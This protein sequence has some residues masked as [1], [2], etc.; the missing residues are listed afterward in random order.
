[1]KKKENVMK[2]AAVVMCGVLL[3]ATCLGAGEIPISQWQVLGPFLNGLRA[4]D[5]DFLTAHGGEESIVPSGDQIFYAEQPEGGVLRWFEVQT[6]GPDVKVKY[7]N[8]NWPF[9]HQRYGS[10][11]RSEGYMNVGY[12]YAEL[13]VKERLRILVFTKSVPTLWINGVRMDGEFYTFGYNG[14]P[15]VLLPGKNRLLLKF[16]G[17]GD[18]HFSCSI[19]KAASSVEILDDLT[20]PDILRDELLSSF[21]GVPIANT[22]EQWLKNLKLVVEEDGRFRKTETTIP[23]MAPLSVMKVPLTLT[24]ASMLSEESRSHDITVA[25]RDGS[26]TAA[27]VKVSLRVKDRRH[28]HKVTFLSRIDGSVQYYGIRYPRHYDPD[29]TYGVLFSLHGSGDEAI[30]MAEA[31]D[32]KDWA[33]VVATTDR[34]PW[35]LEYHAWGHIDLH[36]VLDLVAAR[37]NID[38]DRISLTGASMGGH[39]SLFHSLMF[40]SK[41]AAAAPEAS[42]PSPMILSSSSLSRS[43]IYAVPGLRSF[44]A[45]M[46]LDRHLLSLAENARHMPLFMIH[47]GNDDVVYP[48][49]PRLFQSRVRDLGIPFRYMEVP[50]RPHFWFEPRTEADEGRLWGVCIDHPE[51]IGFLEKQRR[52]AFPKSFDIR[53]VDIGINDTFYWV[54]VLEQERAF[55]LTP[56]RADVRDGR[57]LLKTKNV[58][59][60]ELHLPETLISDRT[61]TVDWNGR[62]SRLDIPTDRKVVLGEESNSILRKTPDLSGPLRNAFFKPSVLVYGTQGGAEETEALLNNARIFAARYWRWVNGFIRIVADRDVDENMIRDFNLILFGSPARNAVTARVSSGL[63]LRIENE[64]V[65]FNGRPFLEKELGMAMVYPNPLNPERLMAMYAGTTLRME[66]DIIRIQPI[67]KSRSAPDFVVVGRDLSGYGWA[68]AKAMG[69][70]SPAWDLKNGDY[71]LDKEDLGNRESR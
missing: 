64:T 39:G 6:D 38:L 66:K 42:Y 26:R 45:R 53:M 63:P 9:L 20:R 7:P 18:P 70:F 40:P 32:N 44:M 19:R 17:S 24:Q 21:V 13:E 1:M 22:T 11:Q 23:P 60:L 16:R 54:R 29:K 56:I 69:F 36:E 61:V 58:R 47:G 59:R 12:A 48:I 14:V 52:K 41:F 28:P 5:V 15:A 2:I 4:M 33:F 27:S 65:F 57:V 46:Y 30:I 71:F 67:D 68:A 10:D 31:H 3:A 49:N 25:V 51:I 43:D 35:G 50:G 34:R 62:E 55:D 37:H 8:T